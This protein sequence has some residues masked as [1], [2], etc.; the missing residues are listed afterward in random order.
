M[1]SN[2]DAAVSVKR[3]LAR[4]PATLRL[5]LLLWMLLRAIHTCSH[6]SVCLF[7]LSVCLAGTPAT[8]RLTLLLWML[9]RD[10]HTCSHLLTL[11]CMSVSQGHRRTCDRL[12]CSRRPH[13]AV[14][15]ADGLFTPHSHLS[16]LFHTCLSVSQ[17]HRRLCDR[18]CCR[19][20]PHSAVPQADRLFTHYSHLSTL[21]HTC[22]SVCPSTLIHTYSHLCTTCDRTCEFAGTP[23]TLRPTLLPS[24][25]SFG[26]TSSR[27][28]SREWPRGAACRR[29]T[30][31]YS[32]W[33]LVGLC[34]P[35]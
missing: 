15:Q 17:G 6:L 28:A 20:R 23:A 5:T 7:C 4:T 33:R 8:L 2:K 27:R 10:I 24:T 22:L 1:K 3:C 30:R 13:S 21:V 31:A 11:I 12:C 19:R 18:L 25:T 14:P 29:T 32:T 35:V 9:L 26:S 34:R 16:T